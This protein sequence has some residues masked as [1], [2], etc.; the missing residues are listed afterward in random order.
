[1]LLKSFQMFLSS[2]IHYNMT[3]LQLKKWLGVEEKA[4]CVI[5]AKVYCVS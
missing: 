1:M 5:K 4:T 3:H 2:R